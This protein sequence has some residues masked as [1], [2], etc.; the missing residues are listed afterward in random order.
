MEEMRNEL[1]RPGMPRGTMLL[2][3]PVLNKGTAFT[4]AERRAL[5]LEGLLP[6]HVFTIEEQAARVLENYHGK[7]S[8]LER[9]LHLMA[10][11]NRNQTLFFKVVVDNLEEITPIIYTPTVGAA[12]QKFG[13]LY[14]WP[15][16]IYLSL[17]HRG[18]IEE[19]LRN[20][21]YP[22]VRVIVVTDGERILGLGDQG[23][24]GMGIPI[25]KLALYTACAGVPPAVCL[26]VMLDVGTENVER[27]QDPLYMGL[28]QHRLR[29]PD[30]DSFVA[31][32]IEAA[33]KV[34]PK[35]LVQFEDFGNLNAFRLLEMWKDRI[36]TF[37]D[38]IQGTAAVTLAG[39]LSSLRITKKPLRDQK[40]LFLGAGEAGVGIA[41][42]IVTA[43]HDEGAPLEDARRRCWLVDSKG[44]VVKS[45][46]DL[47]AHKLRYAHDAPGK[48]NLISAIRAIE[49]TAIIGVS[50]IAK[51]FDREVVETMAK[52][53]DRPIIFALSNP[54][55]KSECTAQEAYTWS[56]GRAI[57]TSG[58]PFPPF[59]FEGKT[60]VAGQCNN[61]YV[62]PGIGVGIVI[63]EA[64]RVTDRMFTAVARALAAQVEPNDLAMGRV[65]PS[66]AR[67]REVSAHVAAAVA[68]VAFEDGLAGVE[69]PK[70]VVAW[71]KSRQWEPRYETYVK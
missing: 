41:D 15:R 5:G 25:G 31:E 68:T 70:D 36:C 42:L 13:H 45:R 23:A 55:N 63:S 66:L 62:F 60:F 47:A 65:F 18:R 8:D 7:S 9:Y 38:D 16:G 49:P 32:F 51:S 43:M 52:L 59:T 48:P 2:H 64:K 3:D 56:N 57:F 26:P 35:V 21:P 14:A 71:A 20:H 40:V 4:E 44:L 12:C 34:W 11:L 54:T 1:T 10:L 29:G 28:R 61:S 58:S 50:T 22:D 30:Y 33:R 53:N 67:I 69:R 46:T 19:I 6:P 39:L 17:E 24:G 27:L 37:N